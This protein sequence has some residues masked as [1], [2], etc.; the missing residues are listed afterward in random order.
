MR[1]R[2]KKQMKYYKV[3]Y[4]KEISLLIFL[5]LN[6]CGKNPQKSDIDAPKIYY[7][8]VYSGYIINGISSFILLI[9]SMRD[10]ECISDR[11]DERI[12]NCSSTSPAI[13]GYIKKEENRYSLSITASGGNNEEKI[14]A[15]LSGRAELKGEGIML[16]EISAKLKIS[17]GGTIEKKGSIN[18]ENLTFSNIKNGFSVSSTEGKIKIDWTESLYLSLKNFRYFQYSNP[19]TSYID[20]AFRG[21]ISSEGCFGNFSGSIDVSVRGIIGEKNIICPVEGNFK[22][23]SNTFDAGKFSCNNVD[24]CQIF[25]F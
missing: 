13:F 5:L 4:Y 19:N 9:L 14:N 10:E 18:L 6:S 23:P 17:T 2:S 12:F 11:G 7:S 20:V 16:N 25:I 21:D 22:T 1:I 15:E 8:I 24:M 3:K